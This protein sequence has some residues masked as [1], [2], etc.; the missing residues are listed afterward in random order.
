MELATEKQVAY[1]KDLLKRMKKETGIDWNTLQKSE[2]S[3]MI[4]E[5]LRELS[6]NALEAVDV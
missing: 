3:D 1:I 4:D 6:K 5:L 2:A